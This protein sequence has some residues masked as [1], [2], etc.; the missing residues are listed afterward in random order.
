MIDYREREPIASRRRTSH[1]DEH[2][3]PS[4]K[5]ARYRNLG[6][7]EYRSNENDSS[8][9]PMTRGCFFYDPLKKA[10]AM[11]TASLANHLELLE[12][13]ERAGQPVAAIAVANGFCFV[14]ARPRTGDEARWLSARADALDRLGARGI[15]VEMLQFASKNMHFIVATRLANAAQAVIR[16]C[17]L[18]WRCV[19]ECAKLCIIGGGIRTTAGL[20]CRTLRGLGELG[21]PVL[22]FS[23]SNVTISLVVPDARGVQARRFLEA[24]FAVGVGGSSD[25]AISFD[26][27]SGRVRVRGEQR[28]L[29]ARQA[30]LLAFFIANAGRIVEAEEAARHLFGTD[31]KEEVAAL[32]VHLHNLRKKIEDEPDNP[33]YIVTVPAEGYLFTRPSTTPNSAATT[34]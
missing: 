13:R 10:Q 6:S 12:T 21:I 8:P 30:K 5:A 3:L 32:R 9:S 2:V 14:V 34:A 4:P 29:G 16:D 1:G 18:T 7:T 28:R 11:S 23:D 25:A 20:F 17:G 22:H 19:P 33:R 26:A 31:G 27:T 24:L 15:S